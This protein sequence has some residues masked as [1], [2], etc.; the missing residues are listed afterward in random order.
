LMA[1]KKE[2]MTLSKLRSMTF[3][4][5]SKFFSRAT[6]EQM[7]EFTEPCCG[8]AHSNP[9]IDHCMV[10][11]GVQWGRMMKRSGS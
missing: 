6:S 9:Y 8:E 7:A 2:P 3:K 1:T 4:Q 5:R 10:C 11:L